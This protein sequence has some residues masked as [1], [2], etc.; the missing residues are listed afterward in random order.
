MVAAWM[1][2]PAVAVPTRQGADVMKSGPALTYVFLKE[3]FLLGLRPCFGE[4]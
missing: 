3:G 1:P 4:R 2:T